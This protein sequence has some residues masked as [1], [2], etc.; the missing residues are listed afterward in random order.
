LPPSCAQPFC[1][2]CIWYLPIFRCARRYRGM[3]RADDRLPKRPDRDALEFALVQSRRD[4][5]RPPFLL[6]SSAESL[7]P[8]HSSRT[9]FSLCLYAASSPSA[10][11]RQ[12]RLWSALPSRGRRL[13]FPA[14]AAS[15]VFITR[16]FLFPLGKYAKTETERMERILARNFSAARDP[17]SLCKRKPVINFALFDDREENGGFRLPVFIKSQMSLEISQRIFAALRTID[18]RAR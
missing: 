17:L 7:R 11:H 16:T 13:D 2:F 9:P 14:S 4:P 18:T 8:R 10:S 12:F 6:L 1:L 5:T 3:A 15:S